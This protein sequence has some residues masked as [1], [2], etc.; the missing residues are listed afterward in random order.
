ML[1]KYTKFA[2]DPEEWGFYEPG[3]S[4]YAEYLSAYTQCFLM[5]MGNNQVGGNR[6]LGFGA[7]VLGAQGLA[8][9]ADQ[10]QDEAGVVAWNG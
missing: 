10:G 5:I 6:G 8:P 4:I 7:R 2:P 9:G 1:Y 3:G